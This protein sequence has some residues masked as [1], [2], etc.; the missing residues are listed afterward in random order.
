LA[1]TQRLEGAA[2]K[3]AIR[4]ITKDDQRRWVP[5]C[6]GTT[7]GL[8]STIRKRNSNDAILF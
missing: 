3:S 5:A 4:E 1:G 7:Q 2:T 8:L 6:A